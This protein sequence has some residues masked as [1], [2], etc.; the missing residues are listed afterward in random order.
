MSRWTFFNVI[1]DG[2]GHQAFQGDYALSESK[3]D[4]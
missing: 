2:H 1:Q 3:Y 4:Y